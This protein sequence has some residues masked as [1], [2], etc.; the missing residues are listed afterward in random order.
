MAYSIASPS[1]ISR[2]RS[3]CKRF[4]V[5]SSR[6]KLCCT[7]ARAVMPMARSSRSTVTVPS[8]VALRALCLSDMFFN[9]GT[10]SLG[11]MRMAA[12]VSQL[13]RLVADLRSG[14]IERL[15]VTH[16]KKSVAGSDSNAVGHGFVEIW[17]CDAA[18]ARLSSGA[19]DQRAAAPTWCDD[20]GPRY[21]VPCGAARRLHWSAADRSKPLWPADTTGGAR[22]AQGIRKLPGR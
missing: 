13:R 1:A 16:E 15:R 11:V 14:M 20:T 4:R 12:C 22:P 21:T 17:C 3:A 2:S 19:A 6:G 5:G 9:S 10:T 18:L 8:A 7:I